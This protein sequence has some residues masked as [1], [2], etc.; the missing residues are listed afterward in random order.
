LKRAGNGKW[1]R[2]VERVGLD[3]LLKERQLIRS[4]REEANDKTR[5]RSRIALCRHDN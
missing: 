3:N 4:A 5:T 1:F 2:I